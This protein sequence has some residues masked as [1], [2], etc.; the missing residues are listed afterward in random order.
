MAIYMTEKSLPSRSYRWLFT[1]LRGT[2]KL[3]QKGE[4][5]RMPMAT[6]KVFSSEDETESLFEYELPLNF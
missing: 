1:Q 5:D 2:L 6:I 4:I 3:T